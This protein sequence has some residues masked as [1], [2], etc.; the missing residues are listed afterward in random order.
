MRSSLALSGKRLSVGRRVGTVME[1]A[2]RCTPCRPAE[3]THTSVSFVQFLFCKHHFMVLDEAG[4]EL[5]SKD[6]LHAAAVLLLV[7]ALD[8]QT[9]AGDR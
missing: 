8:L 1:R 9:A 6:E 7:E 2:C 4:V 3:S 5:N